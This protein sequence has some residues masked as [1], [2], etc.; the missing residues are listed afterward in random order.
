MVR[1]GL[2]SFLRTT[3]PEPHGGRLAYN[4]ADLYSAFLGAADRIEQL[5]AWDTDL[6]QADL[7]RLLSGLAG[8]LYEHIEPHLDASRADLRPWISR[9]YDEAE[10]RGDL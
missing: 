9:L 5:S 6:P 2:H 3:I 8:E 10:A 4:L 7:R 1:G